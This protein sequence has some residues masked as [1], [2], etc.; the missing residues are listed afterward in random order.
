MSEPPSRE[1]DVDAT[2]RVQVPSY[3][4]PFGIVRDARRALCCGGRRLD[5]LLAAAGVPT[6]AYVYDLD[7]IG[8][9]ARTMVDALG[10]SGLCCYAIKA[11]HAAPIVGRLLLERC[12]VDVVSGGELQLALACGAEPSRIVYS[13]VAKR[14]DE[15]DLAIRTRIRAIHAESVEE[16]DRIAVRARALGA[17]VPIGIRVNPD[18][19]ADTHSHIAT[20]HDEAKFGIA[21]D[22][23]GRALDCVRGHGDALRLV[24]MSVHV[25]SQLMT[26]EPYVAGVR[27]LCELAVAVRNKGF[28]LQY[29]DAGGGFGVAYRDDHR[30]TPPATFIHAALAELHARRLDDLAFLIEPGRALVAAH[31]VLVTRTIQPKRARGRGG[32]RRWLLIDAGMNDL[33]RPALYQAHHRIE[34]IVI[35]AKETVVSWRVAGPVCESSDDFGL[36]PLP[37]PPPPVLAIRDAGAYGRSMASTYNARPIASEVFVAGGEVIAVRRAQPLDALV[38]DEIDGVLARG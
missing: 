13:G 2:E 30:P 28:P 8:L 3:P 25:G 9:G 34:P 21:R 15:L 26:P 24:G 16:L 20:G 22:D 1:I 19:E 38:A 4:P 6:P 29:V 5:E 10:R 36:H 11:N 31:G 14:D 32:E 27:V 17:Q 7:A 23:L 33:I 18:V 35:D 12:G 37:D